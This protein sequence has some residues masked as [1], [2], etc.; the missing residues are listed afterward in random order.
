[1]RCGLCRPRSANNFG[2]EYSGDR[3]QV[4]FDGRRVRRSDRLR[5]VEEPARFDRN[6]QSMDEKRLRYLEEVAEAARELPADSQTARLRTALG[7]LVQFMP[8]SPALRGPDDPYES[9][10][11]SG[12]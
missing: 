9:R 5:S 3:D 8:A 2:G 10:T 11:S 7:A 4:G 1:M 6:P 12:W